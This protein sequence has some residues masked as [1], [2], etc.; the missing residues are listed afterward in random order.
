MLEGNFSMS[1]CFDDD[2]D[3]ANKSTD[4]TEKECDVVDLGEGEEEEGNEK[5]VPRLQVF[6]WSL[7]KLIFQM[8]LKRE[9]AFIVQ[10]SWLYMFVRVQ[11]NVKG[12]CQL[13]SREKFI[14]ISNKRFLSN[15]YKEV[16]VMLKFN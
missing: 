14:K 7:K 4:P 10:G 9:N 12:I 2:D 11:L 1:K 8:V 16:M 6:G 15:P 3:N 13:V 5:K